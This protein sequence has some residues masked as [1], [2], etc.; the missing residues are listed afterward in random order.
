MAESSKMQQEMSRH[1]V[2]S[3]QLGPET[4]IGPETSMN[5]NHA[6]LQVQK[7]HIYNLRNQVR[8][9]QLTAASNLPGFIY[10]SPSIIKNSGESLMNRTVSLPS[11][12]LT[13]KRTKI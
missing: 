8:N 11:R 6:K 7:P 1:S 10:F 9:G 2:S 13:K 4:V 5:Q 12:V 3:L